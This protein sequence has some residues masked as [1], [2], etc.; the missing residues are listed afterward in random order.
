MITLTVT[1]LFQGQEGREK[2]ESLDQET[3]GSLVWCNRCSQ[4][5]HAAQRPQGFIPRGNL[6]HGEQPASKGWRA[7]TE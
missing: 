2:G 3:A 5:I 1:P 4:R 6:D 7:G